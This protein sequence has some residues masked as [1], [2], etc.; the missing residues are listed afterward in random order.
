MLEALIPITQFITL[1]WVEYV[2]LDKDFNKGSDKFFV[3]QVMLV[4]Q[5]VLTIYLFYIPFYSANKASTWN[6]CGIYVHTVAAVL[7]FLLL[8][9]SISIVAAIDMT[10]YN[11][12]VPHVALHTVVICSQLTT[13]IIGLVVVRR[14]MV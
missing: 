11:R 7:V 3:A 1:I 2:F 13:I 8:P 9:I 4:L 6:S 10:E 12:I 14:I 5:L